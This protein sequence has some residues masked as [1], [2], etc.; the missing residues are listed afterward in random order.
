MRATRART[1]GVIGAGGMS[2]NSHLPLLAA[3][4]IGVPW[5]VD[6][7]PARARTAADAYAIPRCLEPTQLDQTTPVDIVLLACP[8]GVRKPYFDFFAGSTSA[9]YVEKPV[10]RTT[11]ELQGICAL[12]PPHQIAAGFLRRSMG[13]T[14]IMRAVIEDRLFGRLRRVRSEFGTITKIHSG[15]AFATDVALAGGGQLLESAIHNI[16]AVCFMAGITSAHVE[17]SHMIHED[18]FDLHTEATIAL[19]DASGEA[20]EMD[21]LV[22]CFQNTSHEIEMEFDHA[23]VTCSLFTHMTPRVRSRSGRRM[24]FQLVDAATKDYP[25]QIFDV[26]HV[27]WSDFLEGLDQQRANYTSAAGSAVTTSIIEQLYGRRS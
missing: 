19:R 24:P 14:R 12:R 11:A 22:T 7:S 26:A 25:R 17:R 2:F 6:A 13:I 1:V 20:V 15:T 3:M 16:D 27:F 9:F 5:I 21:L 8:Y 23:V 4:G 10:A 18:H